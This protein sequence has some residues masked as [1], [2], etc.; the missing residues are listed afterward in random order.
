MPTW[1]FVGRAVTESN[2]FAP[3]TALN[4]P[5]G[6]AS[7]DL[8]VMLIEMRGNTLPTLPTGWTTVF[9]VN[10][11]DTTSGY[12]GRA[13]VA[14]GYLIRGS[15][16][17]ASVAGTGATVNAVRVGVLAY[18]PSSGGVTYLSASTLNESAPS[19]AHDHASI[20][21]LQ[22]DDLLVMAFGNGSAYYVGAADAA[23]DPNTE[24]PAPTSGTNGTENT[25]TM[26]AAGAWVNRYGHAFA[27]GTTYGAFMAD[28]LKSS[29]GATGTLTF[30]TSNVGMLAGATM[31]FRIDGAGGPGS[32][33][34]ADPT[35]NRVYEGAAGSATVAF[36]GTHAGATSNVEI[37]IESASTGAV[38]VPWTTIA[39]SVVAGA[40]SGSLSIP[41]G[42]WYAA[43]VR[44]SA[45]TAIQAATTAVFG[46]GVLIGGLGQSHLVEFASEGSGTA[47]PLCVTHN[48]SAIVALGTTGQ[49]Q[50]ALASAI[51][52][53]FA[54]PVMWI[55]SSAGGTGPDYWYTTGGGAT[56]Q[57]NAW[58]AK[59]SAV[60]GKLS[61][62][63]WWQGD[64][65]T[66][67]GD[68]QS[69][70]TA[71]MDALIQ[72]VK[73]D[74]TASK[75]VIGM[76]GRRG[77]GTGFTDASY[78]AIRRAHAAYADTANA[79]G[80]VTIDQPQDA[81]AQHFPPSSHAV[82]GARIA[83]CVAASYSL[84]AYSRGPEIASATY[85][86]TIVNLALTHQTG[87]DITPTG[88]ITGLQVL[89]NGTPVTISS[90]ARLSGSVIQLTLA[91]TPATPVTVRAGYGAYPDVSGW[92][93]DNTALQLPLR[94][95]QA[96]LTATFVSDLTPPTLTGTI[97][98]SGISATGYTIMCPVATD[99][100]AV[101]GYEYRINSGSWVSIASG[102]RSATIT[103]RTPGGTDTVEMRAL[104][105]VPNYSSVLSTT[106]N[107]VAPPSLTSNPLKNNTGTVLAAVAFEAYVSNPTTGALVIKKTGLTS[108]G[109]GVV[110][111]TDAALTAATAYRVVWRRTD[112][113]AEGL[114]TLT[115][116]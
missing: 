23:T 50:V 79:F 21:S 25:T 39:S 54:C 111:F 41:R 42:G 88:G 110:S 84:E 57:Y 68:T 52:T 12:L 16:T 77:T 26:P 76:L 108:N 61:A 62:F 101:T 115:A 3:G 114:E 75:V 36:S 56:A 73:T 51:A 27:G 6:T 45:D 24:S 59:V 15:S 69:S 9:S 70:Y 100:L 60:G 72:K 89:G 99:N 43:K 106:V 30:A 85:N 113:G 5:A 13:S 87:T 95:T 80:F 4:L 22:T 86:N 48:G 58:A 38:V 63:L 11:N 47:N 34:V 104:D 66:L 65:N 19:T 92:P 44:K 18:R 7:G 103:G 90:A 46:V 105:G 28:G 116:V 49:G 64:F 82:F 98:V 29:S 32:I 35:N 20:P 78:Q 83:Q 53:K 37:Q 31:A 107:L 14:V 2:T 97:T 102:G 10:N 33:T 81:D 40:W 112:T 74:F 96:D 109:S 71:L 17:P 93:K 55:Q 8:L 91:T 1:S 67:T 94:P